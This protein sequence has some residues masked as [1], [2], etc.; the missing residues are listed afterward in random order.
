MKALNVLLALFVSA[1]IAFG[2]FEGGLRLL[3]FGPPASIASP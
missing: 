3:G 2:V 1:A